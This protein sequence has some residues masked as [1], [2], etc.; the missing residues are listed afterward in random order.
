M[1][2]FRI[3]PHMRLQEWV[4]DA[5]GYF[6]AEGLDYEFSPTLHMIGS[7]SVSSRETLPSRRSCRV[8]PA[9]SAPPATG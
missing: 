8:V 3:S 9:T 1:G 7:P 4:A 2:K 6:T 5:E